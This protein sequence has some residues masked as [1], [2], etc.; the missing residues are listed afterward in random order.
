[1]CFCF[2]PQNLSE[3]TPENCGEPRASMGK[4]CQTKIGTALQEIIQKETEDEGVK[5]DKE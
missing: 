1:M 3:M 2:R 4:F 5:N